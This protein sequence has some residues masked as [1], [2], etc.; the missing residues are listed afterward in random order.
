[1]GKV[2]L[3]TGGTRG[4]GLAIA[5][6]FSTQG[7][8]IAL[9]YFFDDQEALDAKALLEKNGVQVLLLKGDIRDSKAVADMIDQTVKDKQQLPDFPTMLDLHLL[10]INLISHYQ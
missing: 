3:V 2:V 5:E 6:K 7:Y 1:M 9:N 10:K 4:I 8:D